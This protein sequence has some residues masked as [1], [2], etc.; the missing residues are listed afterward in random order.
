MGM[1]R[2]CSECRHTFT[3]SPQARS[4]QRVCCVA[5]R[6]ARDRRLAQIRRRGDLD[7]FRADERERQRNRRLRRRRGQ[8]TSAVVRCSGCHAP[9]PAPGFADLPKDLLKLLDRVF[10]ASRTSLLRELRKKWPP[11]RVAAAMAQQVSRAG[12]GF[13]MCDRT[14]R[15]ASL[16]DKCHT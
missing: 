5:C 10:T 14:G 6:A 11:P 15:T 7:A 1:R 8:S 2:R 9:S 13:Q 4:T 16:R 3:P 12:I